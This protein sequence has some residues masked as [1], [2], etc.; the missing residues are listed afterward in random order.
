MGYGL[1][2]NASNYAA[3]ERVEAAPAGSRRDH[4]RV[5][6][7]FGFEARRR[8]LSDYLVLTGGS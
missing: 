4:D 5:C 3:T 8:T 6:G 2:D 1:P 7:L